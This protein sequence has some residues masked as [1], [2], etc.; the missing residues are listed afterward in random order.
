MRKFKETEK[1]TRISSIIRG[2]VAFYKF[3]CISYRSTSF[4]FMIYYV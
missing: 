1:T 4:R 2:I 3:R